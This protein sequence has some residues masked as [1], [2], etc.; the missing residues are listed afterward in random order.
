MR[1]TDGAAFSVCSVDF[2]EGYPGIPSNTLNGYADAGGNDL[3]AT[4]A[5]ALDGVLNAAETVDLDGFVQVRRIESTAPFTELQW[6]NVCVCDAPKE[7]FYPPGPARA[8]W[9]GE[10]CT[11]VDH[12]HSNH[13]SFV[14]GEPASRARRSAPARSASTEPTGWMCRTIPAS[15]RTRESRRISR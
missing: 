2:A 11:P 14:G 5:L 7:C 12:A 15:T 3:V 8:W 4:Q 6:D 9:R 1:R 13:G 10:D